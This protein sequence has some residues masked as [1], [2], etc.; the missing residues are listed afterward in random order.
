MISP[1]QYFKAR[2]RRPKHKGV[3]G[4]FSTLV[5]ITGIVVGSYIMTGGGYPEVVPTY[6]TPPQEGHPLPQQPKRQKYSTIT[7]GELLFSERPLATPTPIPTFGPS[8]TPSADE[9]PN[10]YCENQ[11]TAF[12]VDVS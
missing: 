2:W 11:A 6:T 8:P 5:I 10:T 9:P 3:S 4:N 12:L 1:L 7:L